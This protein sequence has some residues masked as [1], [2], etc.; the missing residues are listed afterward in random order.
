MLT[1]TLSDGLT[2]RLN[3]AIAAAADFTPAMRTIADAM[4]ANAQQYFETERGPDGKPWKPSRRAAD[5][6]GRTLYDRG[7]LQ[8]SLTASHDARSAILGTNLPYAAIHQFGGKITAK[9]AKGLRFMVGKGDAE[10]LVIVQSVTLPA[11][12]FLG[13]SA[14]DKVEI[15]GIL[16]RHLASAFEARS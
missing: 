2:A 10:H 12:P 7:D 14:E 9:T 8:Q 3:A 15:E 4:H 11:R 5:E 16:E 6:G 13:F 1:L